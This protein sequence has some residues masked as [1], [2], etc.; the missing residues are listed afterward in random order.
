LYLEDEQKTA[1]I[2]LAPG[3]TVAGKIVDP[4]GKPIEKAFV[5]IMLRAGRWGS[6]IPQPS[7]QTGSDGRYKIVA[8]PVD[9]KLSVYVSGGDN[10]GQADQEI[11]AKSAKAGLVEMKPITLEFANL[12][13]SGRVVDADDKPVAGVQVQVQGENQP[14][15]NTSTDS[16][17]KFTIK[18][19]CKGPMRVFAYQQE[20][21][22][23]GNSQ[24]S[25]GDKDIEIV[26][27]SRN[28]MGP[29]VPQQKS[30][31][32]KPLPKLER[33]NLSIKTD[34][35]KG[36]KLLLVFYDPMSRPSRHAVKKIEAMPLAEK[37]VMLLKVDA[38]KLNDKTKQ[39]FGLRSLPWLI[40]TD[41][42]QKVTSAGF[43]PND[44]PAR[45]Q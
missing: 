31:L 4:N 37:G 13:V 43:K 26:L 39:A 32:G 6:T 21:G 22:S 23:Y 28:A 16:D 38:T 35:L 34:E 14:Y 20:G 18:G 10:Y 30:L 12:T 8:L 36:K 15:R 3:L 25:G 1:E 29:M 9:E 33:L 19:V 45:L 41:E 7:N 17:G 5:S 24:A 27:R 42:A 2:K 11:D 44:L 40:L